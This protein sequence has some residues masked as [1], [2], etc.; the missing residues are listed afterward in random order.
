[1]PRR[2]GLLLLLSLFQVV[3]PRPPL[4]LLL[5]DIFGRHPKW[6]FCFN[7]R[8]WS[9]LSSWLVSHRIQVSEALLH[10]AELAPGSG[11]LFTV[12]HPFCLFHNSRGYRFGAQLA[13]LESGK[14]N[15][16]AAHL[17]SRPGRAGAKDEYW[18]GLVADSS[19]G[20][21]S[22]AWSDGTATSRY[23]G[24]WR[25]GQPDHLAGG[26]TLVS[27]EKTQLYWKLEQCN[28]LLPFVCE[29][30]ACFKGSFFCSSGQCIP[31]S[32]HCNG[33]DDC[34]DF[35]DELNCPSRLSSR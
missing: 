7:L 23:I 22:F 11:N 9:D 15:L 10:R 24:Q 3:S 35:S 1:M 32:K 6:F 17:L 20:D 28:I 5:S 12:C 26:C 16:N 4:I 19:S 2:G 14:E 8:S 31:E 27:L 18:I 34:G 30:P 25:Q 13:K 29:L 21:V 33:M